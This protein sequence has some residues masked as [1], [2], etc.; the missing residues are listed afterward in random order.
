MFFHDLKIKVFDWP[1]KSIKI[2]ASSAK[3]CLL[4]V[5]LLRLYLVKILLFFL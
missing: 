3:E 5:K 1:A 2:N 4:I